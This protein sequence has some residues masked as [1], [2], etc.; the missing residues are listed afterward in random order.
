MALENLMRWAYNRTDTGN[1]PYVV[2]RV[3]AK[4][5]SLIPMDTYQ[6]MLQM[7][8]PEIIRLLGEGAYRQ[9]ILS[10][11]NRLHGAELV[12]RATSDN[13][14]RVASQILRFSEGGLK[15]RLSLYLDR[16]DVWNLKTLARAKVRGAPV[17]EV[18][19]TLVPAGS[20][21][22][23]FLQRMGEA[24]S[25]EGLGELVSETRYWPAWMAGARPGGTQDLA[26]FE[27]A[28][29][30][31]Y[32][33]GLLAAVPASNEPNLLFRNFIR[34]EIDVINLR[35]LLKA[36]TAKQAPPRDIFLEGG[37]ELSRADL[38]RLATL[39]SPALVAE[40]RNMDFYPVLAPYL[41]ELER[42]N[43][44]PALRAVEKWHLREASRWGHAHPLSIIPILDFLI[45]KGREVENIRIIARGKA[46]G[47]PNDTLR[48]LL[49]V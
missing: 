40:L 47:L 2:A 11:S 13:L 17:E 16:W 48:E 44:S 9:E 27:D 7:E 25:L 28:L 37:Y 43:L 1:Y 5:S 49:V 18:L 26:V 45:A 39:D 20:F 42:G 41:Q 36:V 12:E 34:R 23:A 38:R 21:P 15:E 8:L 6:K 35:T 29:D 10:L 46:D 33:E 30:R 22:Q 4:K 19:E 3:K 14:A 32:Y 31:L 24:E